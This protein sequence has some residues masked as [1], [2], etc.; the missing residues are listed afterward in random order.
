MKEVKD[1][2]L[3]GNEVRL[4]EEKARANRELVAIESF[5]KQLSVN[6][7]DEVNEESK[8]NLEQLLEKMQE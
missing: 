4:N 7:W 6:I 3:K 1:F 2:V 5:M 8:R